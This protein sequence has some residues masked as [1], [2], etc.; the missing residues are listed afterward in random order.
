M[1][2]GVHLHPPP[3]LRQ[4]LFVVY[5]FMHQASWPVHP[6]LPPIYC[7]TAGIAGANSLIQLLQGLRVFR[8][9][10]SCLCGHLPNP[11]V[12]FRVEIK[13]SSGHCS[14]QSRSESL[15][16]LSHFILEVWWIK[17]WKTLWL[18]HTTTQ[19]ITPQNLLVEL[20]GTGHYFSSLPY[21][22]ACICILFQTA[23]FP[24]WQNIWFSVTFLHH[25][26]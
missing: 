17:R 24:H 5:C 8:L 11:H 13:Y 20:S 4:V 12:I 22:P 19:P 6:P 1:A 15:A 14:D 10:T 21:F 7:R 26:K 2:S 23:T 3:C 25:Y 9:W 16:S 18:K